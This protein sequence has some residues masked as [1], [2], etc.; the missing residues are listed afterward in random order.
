MFVTHPWLTA[1]AFIQR[2]AQTCR[3]FGRS[4]ARQHVAV[5][6]H[7]RSRGRGLL[8][9]HGSGRAATGGAALLP[10]SVLGTGEGSEGGA[11]WRHDREGEVRG[12]AQGE[13]ERHRAPE[14]K[15]RAGQGCCSSEKTNKYQVHDERV[16]IRKTKGVPM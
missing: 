6:T 7:T 9:T 10:C 2:L 14:A 4:A 5:V 12:W 3:G 8:D 15:E 1:A 11:G 16:W 13:T